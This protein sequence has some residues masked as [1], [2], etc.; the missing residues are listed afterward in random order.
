MQKFNG[1]RFKLRSKKFTMSQKHMDKL[2]KTITVPYRW[3]GFAFWDEA[4][5]GDPKEVIKDLESFQQWKEPIE[6]W[7]LEKIRRKYF[8]EL[9]NKPDNHFLDRWVPKAMPLMAYILKRE[10][11]NLDNLSRFL[12]MPPRYLS[13]LS[14]RDKRFHR[15]VKYLRSQNLPWK[16]EQSEFARASGK[17]TILLRIRPHD[18]GQPGNQV[19]PYRD[20]IDVGWTPRTY[21]RNRV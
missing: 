14:Q 17:P 11:V 6:A 13:G 16:E 2:G 8:L 20:P 18:N 3:D 4:V 15:W 1:K 9:R 10:L 7:P 21:S 12:G 19:K 5:D